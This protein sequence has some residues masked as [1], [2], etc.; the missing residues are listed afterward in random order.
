[1]G[2]IG[3]VWRIMGNTRVILLLVSI[4]LGISHC[5]SAQEWKKIVPLKTTRAEVEAILGTAQGDYSAIYQL[6]EGSLFVEYSS[7]PCRPERKGGWNVPEN[8]VVSLGFSPRY[9]KRVKDMKLDPKR[10]RKVV[11]NHVLGVIYYIN[12]EDGITF[13]IQEGKIDSID[14]RP[15]KNTTIYYAEPYKKTSETR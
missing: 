4:I 8:V 6:K 15:Q 2:A 1:M 5:C 11:D 13:E 3:G 12:D 10:F 9:K 14:Y 7:G